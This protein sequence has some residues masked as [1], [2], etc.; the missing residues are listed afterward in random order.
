MFYLQT[1]A[2]TRQITSDTN[3]AF[4]LLSIFSAGSFFGRILPNFLAD[5]FGAPNMLVPCTIAAGVW[6][7]GWIAITNVVG[8]T[9]FAVLYEFLAGAYVSLV[10]PVI[11]DLTPDMSAL[12]TWIGMS[13]FISAFGLLIGNPIGGALVNIQKRRFGAGQGFA[14]GVI[15]LGALLLTAAMMLKGWHARS[16]KT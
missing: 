4:Y 12:G 5:K 11:V 2:P 10:P 13:L 1:Y 6:C 3:Y 9:I 15:L 8:I 14:G 16:L 7:L